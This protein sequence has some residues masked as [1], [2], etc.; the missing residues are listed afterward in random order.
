MAKK[1]E[2]PKAAAGGGAKT[3][4]YRPRLEQMYR[5]Q[6]RPRLMEEFGL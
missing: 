6:V 2:R 3:N 4:G 5:D 1:K